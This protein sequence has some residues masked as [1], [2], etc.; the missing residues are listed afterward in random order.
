M[1]TQCCIASAVCLPLSGTSDFSSLKAFRMKIRAKRPAHRV[2]AHLRIMLHTPKIQ[3]FARDEVP[4][5]V[6]ALQRRSHF[7]AVD[8]DESMRVPFMLR[9]GIVRDIIDRLRKPDPHQ[10]AR[11]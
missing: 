9:V 1:E 4:S 8:N 11:V 7:L 2:L 5:A 3:A 6:W 10:C